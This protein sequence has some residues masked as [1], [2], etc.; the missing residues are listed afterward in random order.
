[1]PTR[2]IPHFHPNYPHHQRGLMSV[3]ERL[4][5]QSPYTGKGVVIAL[6][7]AGFYPHPD[8]AGRILL[9][10]DASTQRVLEEAGPSSSQVDEPMCWHGEMTSVIAAGDGR[11]SGGRFISLAPAAQ[12][13]LIKVST[14]ARQVKE[15]DIMRGLR[16]LIDARRRHRID[17]VNIS[18]GG[19]FVSSDP[20]HFLHR[21]IRKLHESGI[22]VVMSSGNHGVGDVVPPA[23]SPFGIT[24]GGYDDHNTLDRAHWE[25]YHSNWGHD[26]N[27]AAKPDIIAPAMWIPSPIL[28]G[29]LVAREARWLAPL[30]HAPHGLEA[31]ARAALRHLLKEGYQDLKIP[32]EQAKDPSS[33][34]YADLQ[35]R[36][37]DYK[38]VDAHHHHADGTSVAAPIVTSLIAQMLEAHPGLGPDEV[39]SILKETALP[40]VQL[41]TARQGAGALN[42]AAA[43]AR[44]S[45]SKSGT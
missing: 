17:I 44:L 40:L 5:L 39:K 15:A 41:P 2:H 3:G 35:K 7:D 37:H 11:L 36:I 14:P 9:H 38:L 1:M 34:L 20:E 28:P 26:L 19:D 18:V 8:L 12:L 4:A 33:H 22:T 42:A 45:S 25:A 16:W 43:L 27:G 10:V 6:V 23:S 32:A 31:E 13:I 30:L 21:A 29:T 24:V